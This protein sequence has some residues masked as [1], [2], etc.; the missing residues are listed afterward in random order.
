MKRCAREVGHAARR[1][2]RAPKSQ[3]KGRGE[4]VQARGQLSRGVDARDRSEWTAGPVR[5]RRRLVSEREV[6]KHRQLLVE[7]QGGV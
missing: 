3:A 1:E 6:A 5:I 2:R 4:H 7:F